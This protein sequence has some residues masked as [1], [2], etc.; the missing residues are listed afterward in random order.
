MD[1]KGLK[2]AF[3][4][5]EKDKETSWFSNLFI[6]KRRCIYISLGGCSI[7]NS[8]LSLRGVGR[9]SPLP[10]KNMAPSCL[11]WKIEEKKNQKK[12]LAV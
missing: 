7:L 12:S 3:Y 10:T 6:F 11:H 9:A 1:L 5:R 2:D 4:G 8:G